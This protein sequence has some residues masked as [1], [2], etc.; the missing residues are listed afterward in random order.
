MGVAG[1]AGALGGM[2]TG[3]AT[4][5]TPSSWASGG[6]EYYQQ[7]VEDVQNGLGLPAAEFVY[8]DTESAARDAFFAQAG[9]EGQYDTVT[10]FSPGAD[11]PFTEATRFEVTT[12]P[13]SDYQVQLRGDFS[14]AFSSGDVML[15]VAYLRSPTESP[16]VVMDAVDS[17]NYGNIT[18][19]SQPTVGSEWGVTTSRSS[20]ARTRQPTSGDTSS[21][22]WAPKNRPSR[23]AGSLSS[24]S[25]PTPPSTNSPAGSPA[26]S[27]APTTSNWSTT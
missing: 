4:A 2:T 1:A 13:E 12:A 15:G 16:T 27:T 6:D 7:L 22:S 14:E 11:V 20:S 26:R 8:A 5:D 21:S 19:N 3:T 10:E 9:Q 24:T 18:A 25:G 17:G 23:S